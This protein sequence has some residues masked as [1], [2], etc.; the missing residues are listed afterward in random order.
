VPG[1]RGFVRLQ[2]ELAAASG[3][4]V[5]QWRPPELDLSAVES[6]EHRTVLSGTTVRAEGLESFKNNIMDFLRRP[7]EE[8]PPTSQHGSALVF[9][10]MESQDHE[11]GRQ[12][13]DVLEGQGVGYSL[14]LSSGTP[15]EIREDLELNLE[16]C[17]A[18][19]IVYGVATIRWVR[20]QLLQHRKILAR[21]TENLK[22]FA[23]FRGAAQD[24]VDLDLNIPG[25]EFVPVGPDDLQ[26]KVGEFVRLVEGYDR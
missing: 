25:I 16:N 8:P 12:V 11:L 26:A 7:K 9:V 13:C 14:P 20:S 15:A 17:D 6:E 19:I 24:H 21:R 18:V 23:V 10:N 22:A 2:H 1:R 3:K 5:L 4:P